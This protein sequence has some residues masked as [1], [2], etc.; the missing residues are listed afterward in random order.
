VDPVER[1][2]AKENVWVFMLAGQSNMAG[3]DFVEPQDTL[4]TVLAFSF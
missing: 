3:R 1:I 4:P 2:P